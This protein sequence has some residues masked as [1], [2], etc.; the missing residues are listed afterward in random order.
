MAR[1]G[2]LK[3]NI[4]GSKLFFNEVVIWMAMDVGGIARCGGGPL[5]APLGRGNG[6]AG[7]TKKTLKFSFSLESPG[8]FFRPNPSPK[9]VWEIGPEIF[10]NYFPMAHKGAK[11]YPGVHNVFNGGLVWGSK[12]WGDSLDDA[13]GKPPR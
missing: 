5:T 8:F 11:E 7:E 4:R 3:R 12:R 10:Q 6:N 13:A 9:K 1:K 2:F